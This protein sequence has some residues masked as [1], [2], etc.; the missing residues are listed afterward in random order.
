VEKMLLNDPKI[1]WKTL[2]GSHVWKMNRPDSDEDLFVGQIVDIRSILLGNRHDGGHVT[3]T[4]EKDEVRFEIGH[5]IREVMKGNFNIVLGVVSPII[6]ESS[7]EF[8]A[9]RTIVLNNPTK[10]MYNSIHGMAMHN[11]K[12][13][14]EEKRGGVADKQGLY[15]KKL[16][17]ITRNLRYGI[18]LLETG[19][20]V[21]KGTN[22]SD[23]KIINTLLEELDI[24]F[25]NSSL[26]MKID[27]MIYE[28]LLIKIRMDHIPA[29]IYFR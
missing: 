19:K 28:D 24:A 17:T 27:P 15:L 8:E 12:H 10:N 6:K 25:I 21:F 23:P 20:Y 3:Q 26:P 9:L 11:L 16:N 14:I 2:V 29:K 13:F 7:P 22:D 18:T 4:E 5:V 1:L